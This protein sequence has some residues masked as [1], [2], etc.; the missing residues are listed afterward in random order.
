[1]VLPTCISN[2]NLLH[3]GRSK[4]FT[5]LCLK[6]ISIRSVSISSKESSEMMRLRSFRPDVSVAQS[7]SDSSRTSFQ[8]CY[9]IRLPTSIR[10]CGSCIMNPTTIPLFLPSYAYPHYENIFHKIDRQTLIFYTSSGLT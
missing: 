9:V 6:H 8:I 7:S 2:G 1:M 4:I 5:V 10:K 3:L